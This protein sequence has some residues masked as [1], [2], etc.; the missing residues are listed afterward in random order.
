MKEHTAGYA[1]RGRNVKKRG[2]SAERPPGEWNEY[3]I[4]CRGD[5]IRVMVNGV[6][7]NEAT[8]CTEFEGRIGLQSEGAE[9]EFRNIYLEPL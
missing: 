8:R 2:D 1:G 4:V 9:V 6:L 5:S 3:D 7:M